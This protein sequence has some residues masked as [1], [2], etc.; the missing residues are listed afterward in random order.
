[1]VE[2]EVSSI[3]ISQ[4]KIANLDEGTSSVEIDW[5]SLGG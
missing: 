4:S 1:M 2:G 5:A 3:T